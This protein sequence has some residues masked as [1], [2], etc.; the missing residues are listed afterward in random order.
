MSFTINNK[1]GFIDS[2]Q[3]LSSS[4]DDLVKNLGKND[5]RYSSQEFDNNVLDIIEQK[6]FY[7]HKY[8]SDF[9]KFKEELRRKEKFYIS[10][11]GRK[12]TNKEYAHVLN[13]WNKFEMKTM[14]DYHNLFKM[15]HFI[16]SR[17]VWK[18]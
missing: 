13:V 18:I 11:N 9:E 1:L 17:C 4:L 10:L 8:M 2:F 16:I 7:T 14:K 6:R 3:F 12:I 5:F 15:W